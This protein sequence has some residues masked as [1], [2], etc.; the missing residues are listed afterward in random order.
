VPQ[1]G[2]PRGVPGV[3]QPGH[4]EPILARKP[5]PKL[6]ARC[7]EQK[8]LAQII[9][10]RGRGVGQL[11]LLHRKPC[12][13]IAGRSRDEQH[14]ARL[15]T[16]AKHHRRPW[17][18]AEHLYGDTERTARRIPSNERHVVLARER[19]ES[20]GELRQPRRVDLRQRE[21][22]KR[23]RVLLGRAPAAV[24]AIGEEFF[25]EAADLR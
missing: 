23:P 6:D 10:S 9:R 25:D 2:R 11:P 18:V 15:A 24:L 16:R 8:T 19:A 22:E 13:R 20:R 5:L 3:I 7:R 12:A 1:L 17:R 4:P 21:R 14:I